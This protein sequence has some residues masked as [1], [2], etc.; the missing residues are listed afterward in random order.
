MDVES[1]LAPSVSF[2]SLTT[3]EGPRTSP[4]S[5]SLPITTVFTFPSANAPALQMYKN[6]MAACKGIV[7]QQG[8]GGLFNGISPTIAEIIPYAGMQYGFYD[9]FKHALLVRRLQC[10]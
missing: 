5:L 8:I 4:A 2:F 7:R 1:V 10:H 3:V 9:V 6:M